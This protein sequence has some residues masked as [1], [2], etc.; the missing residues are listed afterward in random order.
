MEHSLLVVFSVCVSMAW[1]KVNAGEVSGG[2]TTVGHTNN[3][4]EPRVAYNQ[5]P[6]ELRHVGAYL[7]PDKVVDGINGVVKQIGKDIGI[8]YV[9]TSLI[10]S[11]T[12]NIGHFLDPDA[13]P[14]KGNDCVKNVGVYLD[15]EGV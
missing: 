9:D 2:E 5:P 10:S 7:D 13:V 12:K 11:P 14:N 15:P 8:D 4:V 3:F 1:F 6:G